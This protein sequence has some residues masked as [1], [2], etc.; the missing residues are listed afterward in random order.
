MQHIMNQGSTAVN[1]GV[2]ELERSG[3]SDVERKGGEWR[4]REWVRVR[5]EEERVG[6][7]ESR[8]VWEKK[9]ESAV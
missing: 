9:S 7:S 2:L 3:G 5:E 6:E 8:G 4:G 1:R